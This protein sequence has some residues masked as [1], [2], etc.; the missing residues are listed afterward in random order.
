MHA[1]RQLFRLFIPAFLGVALAATS[2]RA[3]ILGFG[4]F[5]DFQIN[6]T[7][8]GS[9]VTLSLS[10]ESITLT[11]TGSSETRSIFA[12]TPQPVGTF[13]ASFIYQATNIGFNYDYIQ[14]GTFTIQ[15]SASGASAI[16]TGG[17]FG[18]TGIGSSLAI[19]IALENQGDPDTLTT[20][21][22]NGSIPNLSS[23]APVDAY[24]GNPIEVTISYN[25]TLLE[26]TLKDI[27]T[28]DTW[29]TD[30][31]LGSSLASIIGSSTAYV[32]FTADTF[33]GAD[34]TFSDFTFTTN[35]TPEPSSVILL[36]MAAGVAG[37]GACRRYRARSRSAG[38][39]YA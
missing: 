32:G 34:Q 11:D 28:N 17:G 19:A 26:E 39:Q 20:V 6:K 9:P 37:L 10:N 12:T 13:T 38:Q 14:G 31:V 7:D 3:D 23:T 27:V 22:Q 5:S 24:N 8:S 18:Y 35:P 30:Y 4:D 15:N 36:G 21:G 29:S 1:L 16:G 33:A 2:A 25:G